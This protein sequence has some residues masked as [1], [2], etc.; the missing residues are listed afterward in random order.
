MARRRAD[1]PDHLFCTDEDPTPLHPDPFDEW[2]GP[3]KKKAKRSVSAAVFEKSRHEAEDMI[4]ADDWEGAQARHFVAAYAILHSRV[5]GVEPAELGPAARV[6]AAGMALRMLKSE[7]NDD[8]VPMAKFFR[9]AWESEAK[10]EKW[11]RKNG[12]GGT[13]RIGVGYMFSGKLLTDYRLD[14]ARKR[15]QNGGR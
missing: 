1:L 5:Y 13:W 14:N 10:Q 15:G 6:R 9:W 8:P 3:P 7:F 2:A 12:R 11:R 4:A